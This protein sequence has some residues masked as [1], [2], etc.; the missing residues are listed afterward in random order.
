MYMICKERILFL[1]I[2]ILVGIFGAL[3]LFGVCIFI[4][5]ANNPIYVLNHGLI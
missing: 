1:D 2:Y 5:W 4:G 3:A